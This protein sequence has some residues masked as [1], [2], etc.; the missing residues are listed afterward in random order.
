MGSSK[1]I[2]DIKVAVDA[3]IFGYF[4]KQDL[5]LLLIKRKIDPF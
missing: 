4:D 3:V 5:Q 1:K 2:Q